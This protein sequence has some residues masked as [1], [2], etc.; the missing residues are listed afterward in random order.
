LAIFNNKLIVNKPNIKENNNPNINSK[1]KVKLFKLRIIFPP[2]TIGKL[3]KKLNF[4]AE[5]L[6]NFLNNKADTVNPDLD[7]PGKAAKA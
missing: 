4:N 1:E 6:L 3:I 2:K 5:A 7:N